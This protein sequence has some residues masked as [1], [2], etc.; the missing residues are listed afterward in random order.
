MSFA[1][2]GFSHETTLLFFA[3]KILRNRAEQARATFR[4]KESA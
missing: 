4:I 1:A 3:Q 2:Q